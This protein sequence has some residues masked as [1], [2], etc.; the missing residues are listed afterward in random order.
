ML[1]MDK[2]ARSVPAFRGVYGCIVDLSL[3]G[4]FAGIVVGLVGLGFGYNQ[5]RNAKLANIKTTTVEEHLE[6]QR[7]QQL[8]SFG[9]LIDLLEKNG[10]HEANADYAAARSSLRQQYGTVLATL[11]TAH[12]EYSAR[13]LRGWIENG[14]L[15]RPWQILEAMTHLPDSRADQLHNYDW[16]KERLDGLAPEENVA[17][18]KSIA[19]IFDHYYDLGYHVISAAG[20]NA[21][22]TV[23]PF[24]DHFEDFNCLHPNDVA[25]ERVR[26]E[27]PDLV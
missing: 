10:R 11:A 27:F 14:R 20:E 22:A 2:L 25:L 26:V 7:W 13:L 8:R 17:E 19:E 6:R 24:A 5:S 3:W 18:G 15:N 4:T 1:P 21:L 9:E 12:R 16:L 23:R